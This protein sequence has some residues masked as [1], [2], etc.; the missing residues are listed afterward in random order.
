VFKGGY[1]PAR[2]AKPTLVNIPQNELCDWICGGLAIEISKNRE[3]QACERQAER[4]FPDFRTKTSANYNEP[5]R[6]ILR[7]IDRGNKK[8]P[9]EGATFFW[10][11]INAL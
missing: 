8:P 3:G 1:C 4:N 10:C 7:C 11:K 9:L 2:P 6:K 5:L